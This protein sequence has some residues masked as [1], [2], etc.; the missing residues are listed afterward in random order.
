M[1]RTSEALIQMY[2]IITVRIT[3][4]SELLRKPHHMSPRCGNRSYLHLTA[5]HQLNEV[6]EKD[7]SVP[8]TESFCVV[9]HLEDDK[10]EVIITKEDE[11]KLFKTCRKN[12]T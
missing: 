6:V 8:L 7:V 1:H 3:K 4:V 12:E 11:V 2:S 5:L 10:G 9:R